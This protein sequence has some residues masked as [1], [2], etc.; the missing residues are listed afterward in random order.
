MNK[1]EIIKE[2]TKIA[3]SNNDI[4]KFGDGYEKAINEAIQVVKNCS[5]PVVTQQ[6]EQ[7]FVLL[8]YAMPDQFTDVALK[9][10]VKGFIEQSK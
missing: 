10:I 8:R 7:F 6:S 2:L 1:D 5:I 9:N 4:G 3:K